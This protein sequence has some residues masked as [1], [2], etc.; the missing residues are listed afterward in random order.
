M[1]MIWVDFIEPKFGVK[2]NLGDGHWVEHKNEK[3]S[4]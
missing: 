2:N 3:K 1:G 4:N